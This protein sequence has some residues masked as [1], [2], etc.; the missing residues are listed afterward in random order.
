[1][2][3]PANI[4]A[5]LLILVLVLALAGVLVMKLVYGMEMKAVL[6]GSMEP[7]LPVGSLLI[8]SPVSYDEI[9]IGDD[10]TFVRDEKLTLVTHRVI[11]KDDSTRQITTQGIANN[12]SDSPTRFENV[13]GKVVYHIPYLGYLVIWTST[14]QGKIIAAIIIIA[15]VALSLL[16]SDSEKSDKKLENK[17][18]SDNFKG[19]N[20][21]ENKN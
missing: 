10:I 6:T 8:I 16:F 13:V 11:K 15:L 1:M 9:K 12:T 2:K 20:H 7:E 18:D 17:I 19:G 4:A 14:V 3:K 5:D 21:N